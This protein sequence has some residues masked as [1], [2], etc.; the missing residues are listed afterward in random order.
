MNRYF[1]PIHFFLLCLP[2]AASPAL[3][4][5]FSDHAVLQAG[6]P[7]RIWG[8]ANPL[9]VV[10]VSLGENTATTTADA[11]GKW[12]TVLRPQPA[13]SSP[14]DL[15]VATPTGMI[16]RKDILLGEVWLCSGQSNMEFRLSLS[17]NAAEYLAGADHPQIRLLKVPRNLVDKEQEDIDSSWTLC[18]PETASDISA[19]G[20]HFAREL[21]PALGVPVGI[22]HSAHGASAIEAWISLQ[23]LQNDPGAATVFDRTPTSEPRTPALAWN[24][25]IAPLVPFSLR[26]LLWYQGETNAH[27]GEP[28]EYTQTF[29]LLIRSWREAWQD[30][31]LHTLFVQLPNYNN[32]DFDGLS[33]PLLREQQLAGLALPNTAMVVAI[34]L[35][36]ADDIHPKNKTHVAHRLFNKAL[37]NVYS[38]PRHSEGPAYISHSFVGN[39]AIVRFSTTNDAALVLK[40]GNSGFELAGPDRNFAAADATL[41]GNTVRLIAPEILEPVAIR[42][43]WWNNPPVSVFDDR[44]LPAAP[45]RTDCWE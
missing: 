38:I 4:S 14:M 39:A 15:L 3:P 19:I 25:M 35:G 43:A 33:W 7:I 8:S 2:L 1:Y 13:S 27:W 41:D 12:H 23:T 20:F 18:T 22:I 17:E 9:E 16:V 29:P 30:P 37:A 26:G 10:T 42:Y 21:Q 44:G 34:D 5:I 40:P 36:D 6:K 28:P 11:A 24:G 32:N 45:F 31:A